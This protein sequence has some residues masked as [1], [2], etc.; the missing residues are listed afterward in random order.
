MTEEIDDG[1]YI[2]SISTIKNSNV[3]RIS[4]AMMRYT[5]GRPVFVIYK[6]VFDVIAFNKK[7]LTID[8]ACII[9]KARK[10]LVGLCTGRPEAITR[11]VKKVRPRSILVPKNIELNIDGKQEETVYFGSLK[12]YII[13]Y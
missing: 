8:G 10:F 4:H 2:I 9:Y 5:L 12:K 1:D 7:T 3:N 11:I 6:R 13:Y